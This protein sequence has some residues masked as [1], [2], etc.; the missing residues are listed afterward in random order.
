MFTIE[1]RSMIFLVKHA[2]YMSIKYRQN[3]RFCSNRFLE[4]VAKGTQGSSMQGKFV[5]FLS[6]GLL[7]NKSYPNGNQIEYELNYILKKNKV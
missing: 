3:Q 6:S 7:L 5:L 4:P 2:W 1:A